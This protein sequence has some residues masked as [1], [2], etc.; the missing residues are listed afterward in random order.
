LTPVDEEEPELDPFSDRMAPSR[1]TSAAHLET[2]RGALPN[3]KSPLSGSRASSAADAAALGRPMDYFSG[4]PPDYA[5]LKKPEPWGPL[6]PV[7]F[8]T[9]L[10][11]DSKKLDEWGVRSIVFADRALLSGNVLEDRFAQ[12]CGLA[13]A[14]KRKG[15]ERMTEWGSAR[16]SGVWSPK[17]AGILKDRFK[18]LEVSLR[19]K[20]PFLERLTCARPDTATFHLPLS[21]ERPSTTAGHFEYSATKARTGSKL[22]TLGSPSLARAI[23]LVSPLDPVSYRSRRITTGSRSKTIR[24]DKLGR[25]DSGCHAAKETGQHCCLG[26]WTR[27][28]LAKRAALGASVLRGKQIPGIPPCSHFFQKL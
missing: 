6:L 25:V 1:L 27:A 15:G 4:I 13:G 11:L 10:S 23:R 16:S 19:C 3:S 17:L 8:S 24:S 7:S 28:Q 12:L 5:S 14:S 21:S 2:I 26:D 22:P 20:S 18:E 9:F